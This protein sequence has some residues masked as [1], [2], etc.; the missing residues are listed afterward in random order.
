[1]FTPSLPSHNWLLSCQMSAGR[2]NAEQGIALQSSQEGMPPSGLPLVAE[3]ALVE[4]VTQLSRDDAFIHPGNESIL[5]AISLSGDC[6]LGVLHAVGE[7][8]VYQLL[9]QVRTQVFEKAN[10][11]VNHLLVS[12]SAS[13]DLGVEEFEQLGQGLDELMANSSAN[14]ALK[15]GL[16]FDDSLPEQAMVMHLM[17]R[18]SA[19]VMPTTGLIA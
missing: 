2:V 19:D 13:E 6:H 16:Y 7:D 1:M 4:V 10:Q 11:P 3:L 18:S 17:A 5:D 14:N 12:L 9:D 15:L 8:R